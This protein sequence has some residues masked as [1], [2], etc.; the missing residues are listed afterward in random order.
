MAHYTC[1]NCSACVVSS[2]TD[3][4]GTPHDLCRAGAGSWVRMPDPGATAEQDTT[5]LVRAGWD[6]VRALRPDIA[7]REGIAHRPAL[8]T[9]QAWREFLWALDC[10]AAWIDAGHREPWE[11]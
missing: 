3:L 10:V 2:V 9:D 1:T 5:A 11:C 7:E 4:S 8:P 6:L